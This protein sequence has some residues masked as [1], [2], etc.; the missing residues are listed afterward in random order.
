MST[1]RK[2]IGI[3]QM[4]M[5]IAYQ[6]SERST[7][8]R[9]QVGAVVVK[10][11]RIVSMGWNGVPSG[12]QHCTDVF[13]EEYD[14]ESPKISF[15]EW[16][17]TDKMKEEHHKFAVENEVHAEMNA[18]IFSA[19]NGIKIDGSD[20][21]VVWSPCIDCSKALLQVGIKNVYYSKKYERDTRG[22]KLLERNGIKC[23][24]VVGNDLIRAEEATE[25]D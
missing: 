10:N 13:Q 22:L 6:V 3:H 19:K 8:S 21:Y 7:C 5:N 2:R 15:D 16:I 17:Q 4:F 25:I 9:V 1:N 24:Q 18:L 20:I 14:K 23:W 12:N 11:D